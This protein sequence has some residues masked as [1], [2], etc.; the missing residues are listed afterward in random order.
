MIVLEFTED[1]FGKAMKAVSKISEHAEC[2]AEMF[3]DLAGYDERSRREDYGK[4]DDDYIGS[5][6]AMRRKRSY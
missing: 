3:E 5:R 4:Y 2:L 1:K 6:Y